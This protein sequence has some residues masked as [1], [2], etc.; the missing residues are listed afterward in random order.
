MYVK[1]TIDE[2]QNHIEIEN[3][4]DLLD[5]INQNIILITIYY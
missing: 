2:L 5:F 3:I 1:V 4:C